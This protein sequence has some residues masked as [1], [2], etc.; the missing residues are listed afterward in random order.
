MPEL[1]LLGFP[2]DMQAGGASGAR[3]K[4]SA[5]S[6]SGNGTIVYFSCEDCSTE[7]SRVESAGGR[8]QKLRVSI[9]QYGFMVLAF[10]T[11]GNVFG[12]HSMK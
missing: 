2:S 1:E 8:I 4:K 7:A 3:V 10:D 5:C 11:E 6:P 9:G 12:L